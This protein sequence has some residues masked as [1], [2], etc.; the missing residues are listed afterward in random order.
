[1]YHAKFKWEHLFSHIVR[2]CIEQHC[3]KHIGPNLLCCR[4]GRL[5]KDEFFQPSFCGTRTGQKRRLI[6]NNNRSELGFYSY[7]YMSTLITE[8][9]DG[10]N[11]REINDTDDMTVVSANANIILCTGDHKL[12]NGALLPLGS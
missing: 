6:L 1:M 10:S 5:I 11:K 8:K 2:S 7:M 4:F 3:V 9:K 12:T